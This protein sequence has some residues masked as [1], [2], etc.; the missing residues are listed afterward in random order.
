MRYGHL[1]DNFYEKLSRQIQCQFEKGPAMLPDPS[2]WRSTNDYSHAEELTASDLAWEWLR[3]NEAYDRDYQK[4]VSDES[5]APS[6]RE[7]LCQQWRL[8]YP[9]RPS[10]GIP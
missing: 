5:D 10:N 6:L 4:L 3:R 8:F 7:E 1:L 9:A 2:G